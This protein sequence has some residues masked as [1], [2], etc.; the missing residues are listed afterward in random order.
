[1]LLSSC[2]WQSRCRHR[3]DG[4]LEESGVG[5]WQGVCGRRQRVEEIEG[6]D[7]REVEMMHHGVLA[8]EGRKR[9]QG[10]LID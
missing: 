6:A 1:M 4:L 3:E 10:E 5:G 2:A 7:K 9:S 8:Q